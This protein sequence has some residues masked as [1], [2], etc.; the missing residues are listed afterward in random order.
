MN[1]PAL[2]TPPQDPTPQQVPVPLAVQAPDR[3][4]QAMN[5]PA[6]QTP[7][8]D[9]TPQQ[10]PMPLAVQAPSLA[11]VTIATPALIPPRVVP[12][13]LAP[14]PLDLK[15]TPQAEVYTA[16]KGVLKP[17]TKSLDEP[18]SAFHLVVIGFREP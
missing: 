10:V 17:L 5:T 1:T 3:V 15:R 11:P 9:P 14:S 16:K 12:G 18:D 6:L 4:P 2:R 13:G 7:P 8:Q